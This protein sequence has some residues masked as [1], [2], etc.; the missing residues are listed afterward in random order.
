MSQPVESG[1]PEN[2]P[3]LFP[4]A[5]L[6]LVLLPALLNFPALVRGEIPWFMDTVTQF[7][8]MR[9]HAARLLYGGE[10]PLWN[11]TYFAGVPLL[12]NP[13]WGLLYPGHWPFLLLPGARAFTAINAA[14]IALLGV[15]TF[16]LLRALF[17]KR[18]A[19]CGPLLAGL[20]MELGGWTWAHLAFGAY[21]Q[22]AGLFPFLLL[23]FVKYEQSMA[24]NKTGVIW[25]VLAG[26]MA[27]FQILAGAPQ[28]AVYCQGALL[29]FALTQ[30]LAAR[31][32]SPLKFFAVQAVL[33]LLLAAPQWMPTLAFQQE[34]ERASKLDLARV[35]Q[36][37]L[38]LAGLWKAFFGGTGVPEDAET[39]LYPGCGAVLLALLA[40]IL[41]LWFARKRIPC[42]AALPC[43]AG[44]FVTLLAALLLS[45]GAAAPLFYKILPLFGNFHDPKRILF[46]AFFFTNLLAG[47]SFQMLWDWR[48]STTR[49][50]NSPLSTRAGTAGSFQAVAVAVLIFPCMF[51]L[52]AIDIKTIPV[53]ELQL[54]RPDWHGTL[55]PTRG[56]AR[57][58]YP[59]RQGERFFMQDIGIQYTYNYTRPNFG[60]SMLPGVSPLYGLE[61]IQG[62]D[63]LIPK[64]YAA[65]MRMVNR[66]AT[67]LYPRHFGLVRNPGSPLLGRFGPLKAVGPVDCIWPMFPPFG[68]QP[69]RQAV[70]PL[71]EAW[72]T[73]ST[74]TLQSGLQAFAAWD[75]RAGVSP[76]LSVSLLRDNQ[77]VSG[78][79]FLLSPDKT[80]DRVEL[81]PDILPGPDAAPGVHRFVVKTSNDYLAARTGDALLIRNTGA[82]PVLLYS[83]GLPRAPQPFEKIEGGSGLS[84]YDVFKVPSPVSLET[85]PT[86]TPGGKWV[87][88][89]EYAKKKANRLRIALPAGH[90]GGW[91]YVPEPYFS[92]W[93]CRV[94]G[95]P[96]EIVPCEIM[97]RAVQVPA[98]AREITMSY[99]PPLLTEGL[100]LAA[101]GILLGGLSLIVSRREPSP[102]PGTP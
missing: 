34:C 10:L 101:L 41:P 29:I 31:R 24:E 93:T 94:D 19:L 58:P 32:A 33:A 102:L 18:N 27:S 65:F 63:P 61:D 40:P 43:I 20:L 53:S 21:L 7:Y 54:L 17:A 13:Q 35:M 6:V 87:R 51:S 26:I 9:V 36:G 80:G 95:Q 23:A 73:P 75:P 88:G 84:P 59:I 39:I 71:Q 15:G 16:L 48:T 64:R 89:W 8:P 3:R 4:A 25:M 37:T 74:S 82:A 72:Q 1:I 86:P 92:G 67:T 76:S 57:K 90:A 68:I 60:V 44:A 70:V 56:N 49:K 62:Y 5:F 81:F 46:L 14:H 77:P 28:L 66:G 55:R 30:C 52:S 12:A 45:W 22:T 50:Y 42:H 38:D 97:F 91:V 69:G 96:A 11:R 78:S 2:R 79:E 100:L 47:I 99:W 85:I 98:G 83:L